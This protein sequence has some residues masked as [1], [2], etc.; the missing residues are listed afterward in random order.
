MKPSD[1]S[2]KALHANNSVETLGSN[3]SK[4]ANDGSVF[5]PKKHLKILAIIPEK[6]GETV[7]GT[8]ISDD[9][10]DWAMVKF[11]DNTQGL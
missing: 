5:Q 8:I 10:R 6:M 2:E 1:V 11:E 9:I 4:I 3:S 7:V